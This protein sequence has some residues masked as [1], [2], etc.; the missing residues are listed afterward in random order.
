V[1]PL[2]E[3]NIYNPHRDGRLVG[4]M[5]VMRQCDGLCDVRSCCTACQK[6]LEGNP[7]IYRIG[8]YP[9]KIG[10]VEGVRRFNECVVVV[11]TCGILNVLPTPL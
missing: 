6:A 7:G 9:D 1:H 10:F 11:D 3:A 5:R 4:S 8:G 2:P